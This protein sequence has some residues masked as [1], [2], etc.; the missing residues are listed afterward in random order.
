M[1]SDRWKESLRAF[2]DERAVEIKATPT[3]RELCIVA[4]REPRLWEDEDLYHDLIENIVQQ[5]GLQ[6]GS[7]VVELGC[8]AGYIARGIAPQVR[9]YFGVDIAP[10]TIKVARRLGLANATFTAADGSRLGFRSNSV[11]AAFCYDVFTNFPRFEV[12]APLIREMY[13]VVRPGGKV[14]VGSI[15]DASTEEAFQLRVQVVQAELSE[16]HGPPISVPVRPVD[17][18]RSGLWERLARWKRDDAAKPEIV[19]YYFDRKDFLELALEMGTVARISDIHAKNPYAG[20]RFN[21]V[22]EKPTLAV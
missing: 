17:E 14:L 11:D 19:C 10:G 12:G 15:P 18:R 5:C 1:D 2:F 4:G 22:F 16:R 20:F 7:T 9:R 13:R 21:V 8:A 6:K 3:I